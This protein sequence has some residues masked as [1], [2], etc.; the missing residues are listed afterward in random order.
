M[1]IPANGIKCIPCNLLIRQPVFA[2]ILFS[3]LFVTKY[4]EA[5]WECI[6]LENDTILCIL[7][8]HNAP[9]AASS[10]II[11]GTKSNG[12]K[13]YSNGVWC[14][15]STGTLPVHDIFETTSETFIAAIGKGSNSDGLY[16]AKHELDAPPYYVLA[17]TPFYG[18]MF[19]QAVSG[20]EKG[21][22]VYMA[23]G[24]E[25]AD[26]ICDIPASG[27]YD[28]FHI[29]KT[30][31]NAFGVEKPRCADL[32]M[33]SGYNQLYAGGYDE[34][35]EP[36]QGSLLW[37]LGERDSLL[38]NSRLNVT[39][40][41]EETDQIEGPILYVSTRDSGIYWRSDI[42]SMPIAKFS[43]SPNNECVNDLL[44]ITIDS[45]HYLFIATKNN[46]Y[47]TTTDS[48]QW[49]PVEGIPTEPLCITGPQVVENMTNLEIYA[50]TAAGVYLFCAPASIINPY[51]SSASIRL[52]H[53]MKGNSLVVS[54]VLYK[55]ANLSIDLFNSAG[56]K[57]SRL[58]NDSFRPGHHTL[59]TTVNSMVSSAGIY[60]L[61][62]NA[63]TETICRK[64][65]VLK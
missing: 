13:L 61:R 17:N 62:V 22:T 50:G 26:G 38:I 34:S 51:N 15:I 32:L 49:E 55:S 48:I 14:D 4:T 10:T 27:N 60:F 20:T 25:I 8:S 64:V 2:S 16:L 28:T 18:M 31:P 6:G 1:K 36:G 39:A 11:A 35:P 19:P 57:I 44:P 58:T 3:L 12:I 42:M 9:S 24:N 41:A 47:S 45:I 21:D 56:K 63:D 37:T 33:L 52:K 23:S 54:F 59:S 29:L 5:A 65:L 7:I 30:P 46:V 43:K 53:Y 40:L